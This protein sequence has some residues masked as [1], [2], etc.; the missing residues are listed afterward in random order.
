MTTPE[1]VCAVVLTY[2]RPTTLRQCL[3]CLL[4]QTRPPEQILVVDNA[5]TDD[6]LAILALEFP[7]VQVLALSPNV[8]A[9]GGFVAGMERAYGAGFDWLWLMDDDAYP[10]PDA[11]E[12]LLAGGAG[13]EVRVPWQ[14]SQRGEL[15]GAWAWAGGRAVEAPPAARTGQAPLELFAFIGPLISRAAIA[16]VG[17]PYADYFIDMFDWE[18]SL[19][20]HQAGLRAVLVPQ[21]VIDHQLGQSRPARLL[22]RFGPERA[23]YWEPDWRLYY[24][25][26]NILLTVRR[27]Q[28]GPAA[29]RQALLRQLRTIARDLIYWPGDRARLRLWSLAVLHGLRGVSGERA[30]LLTPSTSKAATRPPLGADAR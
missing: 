4:A 22:G 2:N 30:R 29:L 11:L 21:S 10:H 16:Q 1:T 3:A 28:L 7:Q 20:L 23:C 6:T 14:R 18:Y 24:N 13:A 9:A 8:G 15:Y 25:A 12:Q 26:R 19:R 27:R 5:S 17:L